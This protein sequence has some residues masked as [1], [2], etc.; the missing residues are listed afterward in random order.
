MSV[1][2]WISRVNKLCKWNKQKVNLC[3][4]I[5]EGSNIFRITNCIQ[6]NNNCKYTVKKTLYKVLKIW[7]IKQANMLPIFLEAM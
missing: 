2:L 6:C 1:I 4:Y 5:K 7:C 3:F